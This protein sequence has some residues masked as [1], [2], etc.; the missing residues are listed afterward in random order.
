M[1]SFLINYKKVQV[2]KISKN[3]EGVGNEDKE[4]T[5]LGFVLAIST[6]VVVIM[7]RR[8]SDLRQ[9]GSIFAPDSVSL[10]FSCCSTSSPRSATFPPSP[11][12]PRRRDP[13]FRDRIRSGSFP[14]YLF[15]IPTSSDEKIVLN[16]LPDFA[17][18]EGRMK[19]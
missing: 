2:C 9:V 14:D 6:F 7:C 16:G 4:R 3:H 15:R 8:N 1:W 10:S 13:T 11:S 5:L 19:L 17:Q 12:S 18:P